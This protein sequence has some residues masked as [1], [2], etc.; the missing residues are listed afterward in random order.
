LPTR[1]GLQLLS[2]DG[3]LE[4][5]A[6]SADKGSVVR[7]VMA[8]ATSRAAIAFLGDD[9]TDEDGFAVLKGRGLGVLVA[10]EFRPTAADA[11]LRLPHGLVRFLLD[12]ANACGGVQ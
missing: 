2:F 5:R 9:L 11:W 8:H 3:G 7:R 6:A 4:I 10:N 1:R 12:W